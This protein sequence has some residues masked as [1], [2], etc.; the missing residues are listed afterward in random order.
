MCFSFS[1]LLLIIFHGGTMPTYEVNKTSAVSTYLVNIL[2]YGSFYLF[3]WATIPSAIVLIAISGYNKFKGKSN[4]P[5]I[6][7]ETILLISNILIIAIIFLIAILFL[8]EKH[9]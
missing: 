3:I 4:W 7:T 2:A 6:K 9:Y 5:F 8:K 1:L